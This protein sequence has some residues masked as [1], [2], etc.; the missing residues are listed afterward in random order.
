MEN[1]SIHSFSTGKQITKFHIPGNG[2]II[3]GL[4]KIKKEPTLSEVDILKSKIELLELELQKTREESYDE[5]FNAC[6]RSL[7]EQN[8]NDIKIEK[9]LIFQLKTNLENEIKD[10][11]SNIYHPILEISKNIASKILDKE[12]DSSKKWINTIQS[13]IEKFCKE[14]S[15]QMNMTI[16][17][18]SDS[19]QYFQN[20]EFEI[21]KID[22]KL[23]S[24]IGDDSLEHGEC[25]IESDKNIIDATFQT[26]ITHIIN[27]IS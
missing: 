3:N 16:K 15:E 4:P 25:I 24:F 21:E 22:S 23:L 12:L 27:N 17:V 8:L 11:V 10:T 1:L 6:K 5:G 2:V 7:E 9:E 19:V 18:H 13:K 20:S 26:Q 14:L